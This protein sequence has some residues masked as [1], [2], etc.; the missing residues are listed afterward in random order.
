MWALYSAD[1]W[2]SVLSFLLEMSTLSMAEEEDADLLEADLKTVLEIT[3]SYLYSGAELS[4]VEESVFLRIFL[5]NLDIPGIFPV[6]FHIS[7][8]NLL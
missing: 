8:L 5:T 1:A 7:S 6:I 3:G 2:I 4:D